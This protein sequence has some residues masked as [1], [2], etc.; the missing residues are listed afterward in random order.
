MPFASDHAFYAFK[1]MARIQIERI[2]PGRLQ[3]SGHHERMHLTL[4][5]EAAKPALANVSR[6]PVRFDT[7]VKQ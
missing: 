7:F 1:L 4:K 3:Q 6:Q 5:R 2:Q